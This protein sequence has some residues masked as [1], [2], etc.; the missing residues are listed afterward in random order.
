MATFNTSLV[1][2]SLPGF[3]AYA[4]SSAKLTVAGKTYSIT[5]ADVSIS[6]PT[7]FF[8]PGLYAVGFIQNPA[9]DQEG[10]VQ[11]YSSVSNNF[12]VDV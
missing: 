2:F 8:S 4:P 10:F 5:D 7:N 9:M 12:L 6:D 3:N 11:D 1:D